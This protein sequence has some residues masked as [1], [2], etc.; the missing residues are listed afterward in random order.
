MSSFILHQCQSCRHV[1]HI[2]ASLAAFPGSIHC[3]Q[4]GFP[5]SDGNMKVEDELSTLLEKHLTMGVS[6]TGSRPQ[7]SFVST[8]CPAPSPIMYSISQHYHHSS[9]LASQTNGAQGSKSV[10]RYEATNDGLNTLTRH[11]VDPSSLSPDQLDL[12]MSSEDEQRSFS[13]QAWKG[14]QSIREQDLASR[15]RNVLSEATY[16]RTNC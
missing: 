6:Q 4:C 7:M 11:D 12:F 1:N 8:S 3:S 16:M 2:D 10:Q 5:M 9:H 14:C 15:S 13:L